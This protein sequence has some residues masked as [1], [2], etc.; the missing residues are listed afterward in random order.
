MATQEEKMEF[1]AA[2]E[3]IANNANNADH[4]FLVKGKIAIRTA[5][6]ND[7]E[8]LNLY[9]NAKLPTQYSI[10]K[11]VLLV[12]ALTASIDASD[13]GIDFFRKEDSLL[14]KS[15]KNGYF[16]LGADK[17]V[18]NERC[19]RYSV[20]SATCKAFFAVVKYTKTEKQPLTAENIRQW[21][22]KQNFAD[23][24]LKEKLL[25]CL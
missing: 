18:F 24:A 8:L 1:I 7:T 12:D 19:K 10:S 16:I 2:M 4:T 17:N 9:M 21:I 20:E 22:S 23:I 11:R 6:N 5:I 25:A 3:S 14:D 15:K 13:A